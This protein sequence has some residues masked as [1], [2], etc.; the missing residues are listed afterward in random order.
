MMSDY[1]WDDDVL[2][3]IL[4]SQSDQLGEIAVEAGL[5]PKVVYRHAD[6]RGRDLMRQDFETIDISFAVMDSNTKIPLRYRSDLREANMRGWNLQEMDLRMVDLLKANLIE[7]NM[8]KANLI[9]A[10]LL[11]ANFRNA[12][13]QEADMLRANLRRATLEG[14][15]LRSANLRGANL[16]GANLHDADLRGSDLQ[17]VHLEEA[18]LSGA[19]LHEA[20]LR[21]ANL[22]YA[23][24]GFAK[25]DGAMLDGAMMDGTNLSY[26][27]TNN[28]SLRFA[29]LVSIDLSKVKNLT[30]RQIN[31]AYGDAFTVA[32]LPKHLTAPTDWSSQE[33]SEMEAFDAWQ[34]WIRERIENASAA[35]VSN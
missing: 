33:L 3:K 11:E 17:E 24:L 18:D 25:L 28:T 16:R 27:D 30:Q 13:L 21:E 23:N 22:R 15:D 5:D 31:S 7:A 34:S 2:E 35:D 19:K 10:N 4:E 1:F 9:E 14:A 32:H 6:L 20:N 26:S 8:L 12:N 29:S